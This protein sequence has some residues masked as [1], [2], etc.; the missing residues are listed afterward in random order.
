[1]VRYSKGTTI[2][3]KA[4]APLYGSLDDCKDEA[5]VIGY[6]YK[7]EKYPIVQNG[8]RIG[9]TSSDPI[10]AYAI[11]CIS[12]HT[13]DNDNNFE[14]VIMDGSELWINGQMINGI[15]N[16]N[17][18]ATING[19]TVPAYMQVNNSASQYGSFSSENVEIGD[20]SSYSPM[21]N[22]PY[23]KNN[24]F[25]LS[26]E[27]RKGFLNDKE[28][29]QSIFN[30]GII[31]REDRD[32]KDPSKDLLLYNKFDRNGCVD[33]YNGFIGSKEYVFFTRPDLHL[34]QDIDS[35]NKLNEELVRLPLFEDYFER[36]PHIFE[37]LQSSC[38]SNR[39][40]FINILT[41]TISDP[42]QLPDLQ[43]RLIETG[44]NTY[45]TK[46]HY[47]GTSHPSDED[48]NFSTVFTDNR[49]MEVFTLFKLFDE[50]EKQKN[51]G[52]ITPRTSAYVVNKILYDQISIFKIVVAEDG[53]SVLYFAKWTGCLPM[54]VPTDSLSDM[55]NINGNLNLSINWHA[56][57]FDDMDKEILQD[58]N[59]VVLNHVGEDKIKADE[60]KDIKLFDPVTGMSNGEWANYPYI[61][62]IHEE[63]G[64]ELSRFKKM[65]R[66]KLKWR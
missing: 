21:V 40:P 29:R 18:T 43:A 58:F 48:V 7:D 47:R 8:V 66:Y 57:F 6:A 50:Y 41:N 34:F 51:L 30:M 61:A 10:Y 28:I 32:A 26:E 17:T 13:K 38:K 31:D 49:Y 52:Y 54:N 20:I 44:A 37:M 60:S 23:G 12:Y 9:G 64:L 19:D 11:Y 45:G 1:M 36:Y 42:V 65:R 35:S 27:T 39:S 4:K 55:A 2:S 62:S 63:D 33:P 14:S 56:A 16:T 22:D 5:N 25:T 24:I 53:E 59:A 3:I 15:A 46:I